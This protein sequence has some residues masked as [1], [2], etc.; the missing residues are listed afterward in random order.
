MQIILSVTVLLV[1]LSAAIVHVT[2]FV[3]IMQLEVS[4]ALILCYNYAGNT[5]C[6]AQLFLL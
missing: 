3:A 4:A 5:F 2:V 1:D 6:N